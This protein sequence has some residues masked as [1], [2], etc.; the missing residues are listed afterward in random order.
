MNKELH[1]LVSR[2][3]SFSLIFISGLVTSG[4]CQNL[5]GDEICVSV[6]DQV[7]V[8]V[9]WAEAD[10]MPANG[11]Y[12]LFRSNGDPLGAYDDVTTIDVGDP[13]DWLDV[14][15]TPATGQVYCY[16]QGFSGADDLL[17][18]SDTVSSIFLELGAVAGT[19]NSAAELEWNSPFLN[20]SGNGQFN[21][22]R[23]EEG[24]INETLIGSVPAAETTYRDTLYGFCVAPGEDLVSIEYRVSYQN[25]T[26]E[27]FSQYL[28][29][30]FQDLLGPVPPEVETVLIDPFTG[31]AIIYWYPVAAPD[32]EEYLIQQIPNPNNPDAINIGFVPA[33]TNEFE[34]GDASPTGPNN[35]VVIA[36]DGCGNDLSY[37]DIYTTMFLKWDYTQCD[38]TANLSWNPYEGWEEGIELYRLHVNNGI[39]DEIIEIGADETSY[40]L[41]IT[42]NL[43]YCIYLEAV[44]NGNQRASTSNMAC[45]TTNY[46][47]VIDYAYI[48]SVSTVDNQNLQI[49][50]LQ[51]STGIGTTYEL[52]RRRQGSQYQQITTL[53]QSTQE[54]ITY[55]DTDVDP[56][57]TIYTYKFRIFDGCGQELFET[58][59][60]RNIVLN[61][62]KGNQEL[63]NIAEW[64][65]YA[66]WEEGALEYRLLRKLGS[67]MDYSEHEILGNDVQNYSENVEDFMEDEGEFC[68]QIIAVENENSY[69][70]TGISESNTVCL[71]QDP[72][73]WIPNA[74]VINGA[75]DVF[76]PV[77]GFIDFE[78]YEMEI[79]NRWGEKLFASND[80][81]DGWDGTFKGSP[82]REDMY[83]YIIVYRDGSGKSYVKQGPLYVF[84]DR[85]K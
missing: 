45:F 8:R 49:N 29:D 69:G 25:N 22:Y 36:F 73:V 26:C 5:S 32:L 59:T 68:Y 41:E 20:G 48:S 23:R 44:S 4:F 34:Y 12:K 52:Y 1:N 11:Y 16:I 43:E 85:A 55:T 3:L 53:N 9:S 64:N 39:D 18:T 38:Q 81:N 2:K 74:I 80:V 24:E 78:S 58:N 30:A 83:L 35:L 57:N 79:R 46:P 72:L 54:L 60:G 42:P 21:I 19:L 56:Q 63:E 7:N 47:S 65:T 67:E 27:M 28:S 75:N 13:L 17:F 51:D 37:E 50:L 84:L 82:V 62:R 33:G 14:P 76:K 15:A 71:T 10:G 66:D 6:E 40:E 31:D 61:A 77:A 70:V